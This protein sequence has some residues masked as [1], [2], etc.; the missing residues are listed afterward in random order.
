[1][2]FAERIDVLNF[3]WMYEAILVMLFLVVAVDGVSIVKSLR[4]GGENL[5]D[6]AQL[7]VKYL[8]ILMCIFAGGFFVFIAA[9]YTEY[10][11]ATR[12]IHGVL[13]VLLLIDAAVSLWLKIKYRRKA[14]K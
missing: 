14:E 11:A 7:C 10:D 3:G 5:K 13:G 8:K 9:A 4:A 2:L 12:G 6:Y 1:M